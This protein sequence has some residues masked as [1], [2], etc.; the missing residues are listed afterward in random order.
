MPKLI[1]GAGHLFTLA[2]NPLAYSNDPSLISFGHQER[3]RG[4]GF[5]SFRSKDVDV[6]VLPFNNH[7]QQQHLGIDG[8]GL[9]LVD[10][11]HLALKYPYYMSFFFSG[12]IALLI[13][14]SCLIGKQVIYT[15]FITY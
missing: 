14:C 10:I 12:L 4:P 11:L 2:N 3:K 7:N 15:Y 8:Y 9:F 13:V 5:N 6:H 1:S